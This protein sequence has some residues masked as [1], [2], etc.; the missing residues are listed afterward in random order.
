MKKTSKST[1]T[2]Q[3]TGTTHT[4]GH[5][6]PDCRCDALPGERFCDSDWP[7][8]PGSVPER[9][10]TT[11]AGRV[12]GSGM[13]LVHS[14]GQ[15]GL[16]PVLEVDIPAE[17][18]DAW[19]EKDIVAAAA[20][21]RFA[22]DPAQAFGRLIALADDGEELLVEYLCPGA[23]SGDARRDLELLVGLEFVILIGPGGWVDPAGPLEGNHGWMVLP[24]A[25]EVGESLAACDAFVKQ[26]KGL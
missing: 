9:P 14:D 10:A 7:V 15:E 22:F 6:G 11:V 18:L 3:G 16:L 20:G 21:F 5:H 1:R 2:M 8:H 4:R 17:I 24:L 25:P 12:T 13:Y 19:S 26:Q 23:G